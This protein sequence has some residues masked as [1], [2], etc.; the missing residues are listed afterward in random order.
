VHSL[1][2]GDFRVDPTAGEMVGP[3]GRE[4][5]DPKVMQV[6]VVL[7]Q[8]AGDVVPRHELLEK[9]WPGVVVGDDVVSRCIYQLRRHLRQAGGDERH[10]T[11]VETLPKRGY[12]L[13]CDPLPAPQPSCRAIGEGAAV[14]HT[15]A[16]PRPAARAPAH[17]PARIRWPLAASLV[18]VVTAV[19]SAFWFL[20]HTDYFWR[21]PLANARFTRVTD[22]EGV[23][24][25][26]AISRDGKRMAFLANR[27][28]RLDA[29]I[30][31]VGTGE[32]RNL[33]QGRV[34]EIDNPVRSLGFT[35]D[36]SQ[37]AVWTRIVDAGDGESIHTWAVPSLGGQPHPYLDNVAEV[38]WSPDGTRMVYHPAA[39]GDP[40]F[41]TAP[42]QKTGR[43]IYI[44]AS[45]VHCHFPVWSPDGRFIY[46]VQGR[47]PD[48]MDIWRIAPDG[49]GLERITSHVSRVSYPVFLDRNT[50]LYLATAEDGSGPWLHGMNVERRVAH[51]IGL[52]LEQYTSIAASANGRRLIATRTTPRTRLWRVP[53][54][55]RVA[56]DADA[57]RIPLPA[58]GGRSPRF[59]R[60]YLLFVSPSDGS[61]LRKLTI[62]DNM[63]T[64]L[65]NGK[66]SR[67]VAGPA[68]DPVSERIAFSVA[69]A[70]RTR[71]QVMNADGTGQ[72]A[73]A[74]NLR[75]RGAPA[76]S[77]DGKTVVVAAD[78]DQ[79]TR[80]FK[81][82]LDGTPA[83][84]L[85]AEYSRDAAW[86]P[87]GNFLVYNAA[88]I[89]PTFPIKALSA[90]GRPYPLPEL[91]LPRGARRVVFLPGTSTLVILKG[92]SRDRNFWLVDLQSGRERQLTDFDPG[93]AIGDFDVSADGREII[94]DQVREE[95]D[96][97]RIDLR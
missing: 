87:D 9:V 13:N 70:G 67:L 31:E 36:G 7:A 51:R 17:T 16:V 91:I 22:F 37:L 8:R 50:L 68:V 5:L 41:V 2:F 34:P 63:L 52:G 47:P 25:G 60:G 3:A 26:V 1:R 58:A 44:A 93:L 33:T 74:A 24:P 95:S 40:L 94:F 15:G 19:V 78:Q 45:G 21:N 81:V 72:H 18:V 83:V 96:V 64:E 39:P 66:Q 54:M 61:A 90:E 82:P 86:S 77:P 53:V 4:Q 46:F 48:E 11:L 55:E 56:V 84:P 28:G 92:D 38:D 73:L 88:D 20:Q 97:V 42:H 30:S 80:L 14:D 23:A 89:G 57:E 27:E 43:Q 12:R 65:W 6:L 76:W 10:G 79:G 69:E 29:W 32:F 35:P 62:A 71:L 85:A 75:V 59:G 49:G